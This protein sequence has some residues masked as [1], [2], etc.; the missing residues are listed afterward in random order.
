VRRDLIARVARRLR[1]SGLEPRLLELEITEEV[2]LDK[3]S[4]RV[5]VLRELKRLGVRIALDDYGTGYSS[6]TDLR[7]LTI[8]ALKLDRSFVHGLGHD[9]EDTAIVSAALSMADALELGVTAEGV[10]TLPQ[11][12]RLRAGGCEYAQGYLFAPPAPASELE[13]LLERGLAAGG[14]AA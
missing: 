1:A 7:R 11:L 14:V 5:E 2:L 13:A 3:A 10:E 4:R 6:L 9:S 12:A 8:D